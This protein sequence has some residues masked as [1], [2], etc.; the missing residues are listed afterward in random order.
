[1][2]L[3][4]LLS[5]CQELFVG[6][7]ALWIISNIFV[8]CKRWRLSCHSIPGFLAAL[9][10]EFQILAWERRLSLAF[11][12]TAIGSGMIRVPILQLV[13]WQTTCLGTS[14]GAS[15]K[16]NSWLGMYVL[17]RCICWCMIWIYCWNFNDESRFKVPKRFILWRRNQFPVTSTGK[18][19]RD[20]VRRELM[21]NMHLMISC[22]L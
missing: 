3:F 16:K 13:T 1:M 8:L 4:G 11:G 12:S 15:V 5:N 6:A 19:R 20:Q 17:L 2:N 21:S 22:K 14:S 10:L 18:I 9:L 7:K